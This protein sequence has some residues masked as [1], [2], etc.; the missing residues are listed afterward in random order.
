MKQAIREINE[1]QP[2]KNNFSVFQNDLKTKRAIERNIEIIG[3]AANRILKV[4]PNF[5]LT[6][7]RKIVDTRN[8]IAHGYDSVSEDIIWSI[9]V[10]DIPELEKEI[11]QL[12][13]S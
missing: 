13:E 5:K 7:A 6:N 10:C 2:D 9:I 8:R 4:Y 12:S 11:D 3:E 1:F